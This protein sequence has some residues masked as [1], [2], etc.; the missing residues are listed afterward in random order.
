M[1]PSLVS[2]AVHTVSV[3]CTLVRV[4]FANTNAVHAACR[5]QRCLG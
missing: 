4:L 5:T 2:G 3:V 1:V